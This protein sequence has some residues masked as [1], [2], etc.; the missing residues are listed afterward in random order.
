MLVWWYNTEFMDYSLPGIGTIWLWPTICLMSYQVSYWEQDGITTTSLQC[1]SLI[2][3]ALMFLN[4][5]ELDVWLVEVLTGPLG[6]SFLWGSVPPHTPP[7]PL[8]ELHMS[9]PEFCI[10]PVP[11]TAKHLKNGGPKKWL[12]V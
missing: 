1:S 10:T 11:L 12:G 9:G 7:S 6:G 3:H 4:Y 8:P 5:W 2:C